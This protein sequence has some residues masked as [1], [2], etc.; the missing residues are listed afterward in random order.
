MAFGLARLRKAGG[1]LVLANVNR[2][3]LERFASLRFVLA[4]PP[5]AAC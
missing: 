3:H 1:R 2:S 4:S 5:V